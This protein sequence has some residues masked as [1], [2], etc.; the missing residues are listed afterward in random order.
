M[1]IDRPKLRDAAQRAVFAHQVGDGG[2]AAAHGIIYRVQAHPIGEI[3]RDIPPAQQL[4]HNMAMTICR[5]VQQGT[6]SGVPLRHRHV[7]MREQG[8][9]HPVLAIDDRLL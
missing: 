7:G 9:H 5:Q 6:A 3:G 1:I 4:S 2:M 8:I